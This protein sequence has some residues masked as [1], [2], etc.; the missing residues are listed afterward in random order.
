MRLIDSGPLRRLARVS[1]LGLV[2]LVYPGAVH[3]RLEHS[4]GVYRGALLIV[5]QLRS[6]RRFIDAVDEKLIEAFVL[7]ALLHDAGHWPYCHPIEDMGSKDMRANVPRHENRVRRLIEQTELGDLIEQD[8]NCDPA[9]VLKILEGQADSLGLGIMSSLLSGPID[10]DKLDYLVRDSL[11][12][13]VPYGRNFDVGRLLGAVRVHPDE[14]RIA[15]SEKGRT[16]AEMMVFSRYVMF[17]EVYWHHAVRS[18][19]AMLQRAVFLLDERID[20]AAMADL[21]DAA[22]VARLRRLATGTDAE[23]LVEGLFGVQRRLHKRIAQFNVLDQ[24]E[25]H[26][27]MA[28]RGY[29]WLAAASERLAAELSKLA[30]LPLGLADVIIDAP[31]AKLEVDIDIDVI[32][33]RDAGRIRSLAEVSP[34]VRALAR[35]QFDGYVKRVRIFVRADLR[36]KIGIL[37]DKVLR[38]VLERAGFD[39]SSTPARE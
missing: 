27:A 24:P 38:S 14:P 8:W 25:Q 30:G 12:A 34:V 19:T 15:I 26:R 33:S 28:H 9:D 32:A 13:G 29:G 20:L 31:P 11:H 3:S 23:S 17:S 5:R 7:A 6:D 22:W 18:A 10:I 37:D 35:K 1:Q 21:D 4:L 36:E 39:L 16:A 2:S